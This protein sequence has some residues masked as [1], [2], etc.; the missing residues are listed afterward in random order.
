MPDQ[1]ET[2]ASRNNFRR[3]D[4]PRNI[5]EG[6]CCER[7]LEINIGAIMSGGLT[8]REALGAWP[9]VSLG[10]WCRKRE[11]KQGPARWHDVRLGPQSGLVVL[12]LS[13]SGCDPSRP[14]ATL[15]CRIAN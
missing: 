13:S 2:C 5:D 1:S 6:L 14:N 10:W 7:G 11:Q 9:R 8:P 15:I 4:P 3:F 12:I